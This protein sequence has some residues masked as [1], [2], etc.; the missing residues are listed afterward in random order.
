MNGFDKIGPHIKSSYENH[1]EELEKARQWLGV[2]RGRVLDYPRLIREFHEQRKQDRPH[3]LAYNESC[4]VTETVSIWQPHMCNFPGLKDK[5]RGAL[6]AG[7]MVMEDEKALTGSNQPRNDAFVHFLAGRLLV[8]G[9][10]V[11]AVDGILKGNTRGSASH[12]ISMLWEATL[13]NLECKRPRSEQK[14][15]RA[16]HDARKQ[17]AGGA[18]RK[19]FGIVAID[20]SVL[21]RPAD[22]LLRTSTPE[23][24][25]EFVAE[26]LTQLYGLR[27]DRRYQ[28]NVLGFIMFARVPAIAAGRI[29]PI[30]SPAGKPFSYFTRESICTFLVIANSH[31]PNANV[32]S[33]I[34]GKMKAS[35]QAT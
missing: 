24:G 2:D 15:T 8:A 20:C 4:E 14:L 29:S 28:R 26:R 25:S 17:L 27:L 19:E 31:A 7:P 3:L 18:V 1:I 23:L 10:D 30:I 16:V 21:L 6:C 5:I 34:A 11:I 35:M 33:Y 9:I 13:I 22:T 12:D 32:M